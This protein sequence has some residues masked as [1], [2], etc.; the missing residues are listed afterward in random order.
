MKHADAVESVDR[1][2]DLVS[3][4]SKVCVND[5]HFEL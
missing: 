2:T 1:Y 5:T 4:P 3:F